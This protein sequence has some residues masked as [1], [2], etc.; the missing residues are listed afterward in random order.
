MKIYLDTIGCRLNQSEIESMARGFRA[1]GHEIVTSAQLADMAVVNTCAVTNE[2]ASDSRG[3]IRQIARAG[4]NQVVVTGC[5]A[6]LQPQQ[7]LGLPNVMRVVANNRKEY[8]VSDVL[9]LPEES[10]DRE[11]ITRE[12]LPGLHRRT[13][14]F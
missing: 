11:P 13:R 5:W 1:V 14:A 3:K 7:A 9:D 2:A 10:F 8:L 4:V 6:T 12:P